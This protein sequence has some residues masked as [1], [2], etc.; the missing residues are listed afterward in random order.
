[1]NYDPAGTDLR[2]NTM[3]NKET[4][5]VTNTTGVARSLR[6]WTVRDNYVWNN[7]G[8]TAILRNSSRA[9]VHSCKWTTL[10]PGYKIC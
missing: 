6:G 8:D 7:T 2:T 3:Y 9:T 10:K 1:M 5:T 4:V